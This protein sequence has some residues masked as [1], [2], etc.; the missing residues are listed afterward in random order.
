[1]ESESE[2][3]ELVAEVLNHPEMDMSY[4]IQGLCDVCL[5]KMTKDSDETSAQVWIHLTKAQKLLKD[6]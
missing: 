2:F 1:M 4:V 5:E 6:D 3:I